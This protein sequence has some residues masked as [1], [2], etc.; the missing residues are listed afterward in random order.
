VKRITA[1]ARITFSERLI[2]SDPKYGQKFSVEV[3]T[4]IAGILDFECGAVGTIITSFDIWNSQLPRIE[5]YGTEGT[6]S[7]PDPNTFGGQVLIQRQGADKFTEIPFTHGYSE[8]SRGIGLSDMADAI[9][10]GGRHRA[11]GDMAFHVLDII[12]GFHESSL[13]GKHYILKLLPIIIFD[14]RLW[15]KSEFT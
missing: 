1:S 4:H 13:E 10:R 8:E 11:N 3:P 2:T 15:D 12:Q 5:I 6:L 9:I 14:N 7:V